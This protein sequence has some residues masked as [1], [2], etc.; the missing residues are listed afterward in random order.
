MR[1]EAKGFWCPRG[2]DQGC[3]SEVKGWDRGPWLRGIARA[4]GAGGWSADKGLSHE[5]PSAALGAKGLSPNWYW[6]TTVRHEHG[7]GGGWKPWLTPL[8]W[9]ECLM[10]QLV[11]LGHVEHKTA[12]ELRLTVE[13]WRSLLQYYKFPQGMASKLV[14]GSGAGAVQESL[15][16]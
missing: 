2:W 16:L 13:P 15:V 10:T 9:F 14:K 4:R 8:M 6:V 3:S 5:E 7:W 12:E 1:E 11:L